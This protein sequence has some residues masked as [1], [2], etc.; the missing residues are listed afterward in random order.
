[1]TID[2]IFKEG[3]HW[4]KSGKREASPVVSFY[5]LILKGTDRIGTVPFFEE[6]MSMEKWLSLSCGRDD[7]QTSILL[8]AEH[9]AARFENCTCH[10]RIKQNE[11]SKSTIQF[12]KADDDKFS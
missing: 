9:R 4:F 8:Q 7:I 6:E 10:Q 5:F 11:M 3:G 1:M 12:S 2:Y